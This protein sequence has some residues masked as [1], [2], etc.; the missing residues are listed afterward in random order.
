MIRLLRSVWIWAASVMLGLFWVALLAAVRLF[1]RDPLRL[2]TAAGSTV[3]GVP[4]RN[5]ALGES[6]FRAAKM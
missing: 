6:T 3:W 1:D 5:L 2:R 4:W